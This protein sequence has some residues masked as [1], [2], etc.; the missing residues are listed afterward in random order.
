[1]ALDPQHHIRIFISLGAH[2]TACSTAVLLC[3]SISGL[4]AKTATGVSWKYSQVVVSCRRQLVRSGLVCGA[5]QTMGIVNVFGNSC[6]RWFLDVVDQGL[7][8]KQT[9]FQRIM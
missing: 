4:C 1:M 8:L 6:R 3:R 2:R 5:N 7:V 9:R